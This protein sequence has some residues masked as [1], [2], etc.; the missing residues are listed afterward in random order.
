AHATKVYSS[1]NISP[2]SSINANRSTSGS[3][4]IPKSAPVST[5]FLDKSVKCSFKGSGLWGNSPL[6]SQY[7]LTTSTPKRSK[8]NGIT[9]PPVELTPSTTTLNLAFSMADTFTNGKSNT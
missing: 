2:C 7:N 1:P 8:S 3:T 4:T 9:I 5:T 6:G